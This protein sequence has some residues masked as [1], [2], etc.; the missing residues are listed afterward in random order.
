MKNISGLPITWLDRDHRPCT[1]IW[2][3]EDAAYADQI[4]AIME[5]QNC[6]E[7][8]IHAFPYD[9]IDPHGM[10]L[11][12]YLFDRD[13]RSHRRPKIVKRNYGT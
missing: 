11:E 4:W 8:M 10:M 13:R 5:Q 9:G 1:G 12:T 2:N 7:G 6:G 3:P